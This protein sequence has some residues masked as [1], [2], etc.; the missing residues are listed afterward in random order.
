MRLKNEKKVK[1]AFVNAVQHK[2][3]DSEGMISS[4][5]AVLI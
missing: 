1:P 2:E 3:L 5:G 4:K